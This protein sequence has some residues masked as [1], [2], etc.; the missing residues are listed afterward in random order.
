MER[1]FAFLIFVLILPILIFIALIIK[2]KY[3]GPIFYTQKRIGKNGK[4]FDIYKMRT[5]VQNASTI[6]NNLLK[7]NPKLAKSWAETGVIKNDPR[8]AG[9]IA[10]WSRELSIDELPQLI[11]II[12]GDMSFIGPRPLEVSTIA[13]LDTNLSALRHSIKPG[14]TGLMQVRN[15]AS[16]FKQMIRYD[17]LYI[18]KKSVVLNVYILYLTIFAIINRTGK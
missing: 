16:N 6:L 7:N 3:P 17:L 2:I 5:M 10:A 18:K 1:F 9:K 14:L 4:P 13:A 12:K 8:I 15:R 11:N